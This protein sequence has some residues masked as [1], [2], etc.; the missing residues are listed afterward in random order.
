[1][2]ARIA[3][4]TLLGIEAL[5]VDVE[6][7]V[8]T[9]LPGYHVVGLP[10]PPVKEGAVRIRSALEQVGHEL[11]HKKVTVNLA[12]ADV[13][14]PSTALDLPIAVGVLVADGLYPVDVVDGLVL[15]GELG[16]DG[17]L[18]AVRGA[19]ASA[20]L[21][22]ARGLRGIVVP[23]ASAAEAVVVDGLEVYAI[24]H[25]GEMIEALAGGALPA[26]RSATPRRRPVTID[27]SDVRGQAQA[28]A[29]VEVA[30]A[31]GHNLLL[32]GPPGIGKTMIARRIPSVL[33]PMEPDE[34]LDATKVY[35]AV[36]LVDGLVT[37]RP[38]RAPHHTV[39]ASALVGGGSS[40]R[41]GEI[42][43]A[44]HGVLFL[45][46][47]PE[48]SRGALEALRQPLEDREEVVSR[49][50]DSVRLPA[51]MM[52]VASCNPCPCGWLGS[53]LRECVCGPSAIER[54]RGRMSGPLLDR[55]DLQVRVRPVELAELR[56]DEPGEPSAP[57]R[58]RV[59][60]A[61]A[62][63]AARLARFGVRT[64]AEMSPT[65]LRATCA[66]TADAEAA[67]AR[68]HKVRRGMTART[69]DR[70]IKVGRTVADL[71]GRDA[72]DAGCILE[73]AAYRALD[74]EPLEDVRFGPA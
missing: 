13:R 44:H 38:F 26:A 56:S 16:L 55:I 57:I 35:S 8:A 10:A 17:S 74:Q 28:R 58:E 20:M 39:S 43:L 25:L 34:M 42:S 6:V 69:V 24:A 18:R 51:S 66:L 19:L 72:I 23:E 29:A 53:G 73:A 12:P 3:S 4:T 45:D 22:R 33:P 36:G 47:L 49:V 11:P 71:A 60:A 68:L 64:N 1:M 37:E 61:R 65:A 14:K 15:L 32:T 5:A 46:E 63:Q 54:Y 48:F 31:G 70:L 59:V 67:L 52:L 62:R 30:V 7:D 9:G 21:A 2:L 27:M 50:A 40:P 41:P